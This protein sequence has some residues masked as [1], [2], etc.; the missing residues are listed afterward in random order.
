[1]P[2]SWILPAEAG[3]TCQRTDGRV[4]VLKMNQSEEI[5]LWPNQ[6]EIVRRASAYAQ[7]AEVAFATKPPEPHPDDQR[8]E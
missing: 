3:R 6:V 1:M 4:A 7:T 8:T 5:K 2:D